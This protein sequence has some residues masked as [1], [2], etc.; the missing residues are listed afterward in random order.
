MP[1]SGRASGGYWCVPVSWGKKFR[2]IG[3]DIVGYVGVGDS[4]WS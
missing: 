4:D 3:I 2:L 1:G